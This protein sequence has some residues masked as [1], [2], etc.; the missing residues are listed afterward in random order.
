MCNKVSE[1]LLHL[2]GLK[3]VLKND[4]LL[5]QKLVFW[6][7]F[8]TDIRFACTLMGN[9]DDTGGIRGKGEGGAV[10]LNDYLK[11]P[12]YTYMPI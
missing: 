3:I 10:P 4:F 7:G 11:H 1:F 2:K 5:S 9:W 8:E 6:I 12:N